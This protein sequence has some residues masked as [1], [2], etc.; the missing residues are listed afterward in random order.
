LD[1]ISF[2]SFLTVQLLEAE[3]MRESVVFTESL[4]VV[5]IPQGKAVTVSEGTKGFIVQ[6]RGGNAT[7]RIPDKH[8]QVQLEPDQVE[9]L[10]KPNGDEL[11][12]DLEPAAQSRYDGVPDDLEEAVYRELGKCY[13]P[14]IPVNIV[15]LGL[16]YGVDVDEHGEESYRVN[17]DMTLTAEG[18]G[19]G[20]HLAGDA[21]KK[22]RAIPGVEAV[23]VSI[24]WDPKWN[25]DMMTDEAREKLGM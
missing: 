15:D 19:M 3:V 21:E 11:N 10:E 16:V 1:K 9:H 24:V 22:I 12:V 17:V 23:N 8:W 14:E 7:V 5:K 4:E 6:V 2:N 13:D 25:E 18:C 20:E